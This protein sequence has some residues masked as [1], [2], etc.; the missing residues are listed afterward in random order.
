[1]DANAIA[2][3]RSSVDLVKVVEGYCGPGR[4]AGVNV[5]FSCPFHKERTGSFIVHAQKQLYKCHGCGAG[6]DAIK[7]IQEIEH[8]PFLEAVKILA[9][10]GGVELA[11]LTAEDRKAY[12][13]RCRRAEAEDASFRRWL[14]G[15]REALGT[16][17]EAWSGLR[18]WALYALRP[19]RPLPVCE[20]DSVIEDAAA[21]CF[22]EAEA[23]CGPLEAAVGLLG[24]EEV[25]YRYAFEDKFKL[26]PIYAEKWNGKILTAKIEGVSAARRALLLDLF[27]NQRAW[28]TGPEPA[29]MEATVEWYERQDRGDDDEPDFWAGARILRRG[30][31]VLHKTLDNRTVNG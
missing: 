24:R 25:E 21:E 4:R 26:N 10:M 13:E 7:F 31:D 22:F 20:A 14:V 17:C 19:G 3:V 11:A 6:G 27:R 30:L 9:A 8:V 2:Q 1:M 16:P 23:R 29:P 28:R 15:L 12:R 18:Q 5:K